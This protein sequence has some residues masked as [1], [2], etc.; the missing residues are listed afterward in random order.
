MTTI[1]HIH[2]MYAITR[3]DISNNKLRNLTGVN[4]LQKLEYI[5]AANNCIVSV[6]GLQNM[7]NLVKLHLENNGKN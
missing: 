1:Y 3:L 7:P 2:L 4:S 5:N 6:K